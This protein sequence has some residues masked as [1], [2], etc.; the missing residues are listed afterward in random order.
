MQF[1]S[2][3]RN[4][5]LCK[6]CPEEYVSNMQHISLDVR[7]EGIKICSDTFLH[8]A[9][10][11][12]SHLV[13][14]LVVR[15]H[16]LQTLNRSPR[17]GIPEILNRNRTWNWWR[18]LRPAVH[19]HGLQAVKVYIVEKHF[20]HAVHSLGTATGHIHTRPASTCYFTHLLQS[21]GSGPA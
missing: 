7:L 1:L 19:R 16:Y 20:L 13:P 2:N 8:F 6:Q 11:H 17:A 5:Q 3:C 18:C 9:L 21:V 12:V 14:K 4:L 10:L 15:S